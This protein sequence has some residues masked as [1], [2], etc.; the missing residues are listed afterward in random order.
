MILDQILGS[1]TASVDLPRKESVTAINK[2]GIYQNPTGFHEGRRV[3]GGGI[4]KLKPQD[5]IAWE[6]DLDDETDK[7][8]ESFMGEFPT[9]KPK[10]VVKPEAPKA[11]QTAR[12]WGNNLA[13]ITIPALDLGDGNVHSGATPPWMKE[14]NDE[15]LEA[16]L[17]RERKKLR[18][19]KRKKNPN[20]VGAD[21]VKKQLYKQE[22]S[23]DWLPNFGGVWQPGPRSLTKR[24]FRDNV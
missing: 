12:A 4:V 9:I 16:V 13:S 23:D 5:W 20:R 6:I 7:L 17:E 1:T 21:F 24:E 19:I 3:W 11:L 2:L 8:G 14:D 22:P 18:D 15:D 10:A